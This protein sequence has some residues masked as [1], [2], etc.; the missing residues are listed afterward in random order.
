MCARSCQFAFALA[1]ALV[2][3]IAVWLDGKTIATILLR[4]ITVTTIYG[5]IYGSVL[6]VV[7]M[8]PEA[9]WSRP[10]GR[11]AQRIILVA[12][13]VVFAPLGVAMAVSG[14]FLGALLAKV[15]LPFFLAV[16]SLVEPSAPAGV[17]LP[18][19]DEARRIA[20]NIAKLPSLLGKGA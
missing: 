4:A 1:T 20:S 2:L 10:K 12:L 11:T 15:V 5:S 7:A 6:L 13:V 19:L 18:P 9:R 8:F 3:L 16:L 17:D 14:L